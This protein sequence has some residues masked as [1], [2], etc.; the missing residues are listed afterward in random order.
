MTLYGAYMISVCVAVLY[1]LEV[2]FKSGLIF[3]AN[4]S[5]LDTNSFNELLIVN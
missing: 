4:V 5:M 2:S 1:I 3:F